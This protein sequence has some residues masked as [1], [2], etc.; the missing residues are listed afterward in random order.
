MVVRQPVEHLGHEGP[1]LLHV[2]QS[3]GSQLTVQAANCS[4]RKGSVDSI[5]G[6]E[7]VEG[8]EEQR[9]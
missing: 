1:L 3:L 7:G 6:H 5:Q 8:V 4:P 9:G 2:F